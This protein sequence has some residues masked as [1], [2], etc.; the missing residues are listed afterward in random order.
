MSS[1]VR[2]QHVAPATLGRERAVVVAGLVVGA[3]LEVLLVLLWNN[4]VGPG[5]EWSV[6]V[7]ALLLLPS[8]LLNGW[9]LVE[10]VGARLCGPAVPLPRL[11]VDSELGSTHKTV[12]VY[13]LLVVDDNDVDQVIECIRRNRRVAAHRDVGHL[14]AADRRDGSAQSVAD[15]QRLHEELRRRVR[16]LQEEEPGLGPVGAVVREQ[17]QNPVSGT[18]MGWERKRG[19]LLELA[20]AAVSGD[21][22]GYRSDPASSAILAG[23]RYLMVLDNGTL[24]HPYTIRELVG[25]LAHDAAHGDGRTA[26]AQPGYRLVPPDDPNWYQRIVFEGYVTPGPEPQ[27]TLFS[28]MQRM[29]GRDRYGGQALVAVEPFLESLRGRIP[30]NAVLSH[31]KLEGTYA[32]TQHVGDAVILGKPVRSFFEHRRRQ[33]RWI[34]G[35]VQLVPWLV[36]RH[37]PPGGL[38]PWDRLAMTLDIVVFAVDVTAPCLMLLAWALLDGPAAAV[39]TLAVPLFAA[40]RFLPILSGELLRGLPGGVRAFATRLRR[41]LVSEG[42]YLVFLADRATYT[43]KAIATSL[44]RVTVTRRNLLE[45]QP[46]AAAGR[47]VAANP[48]TRW[49]T[50]MWPG[51]LLS[52]LATGWFVAA[53]APGWYVYVVLGI[54]VL[55]PP[56]CAVLSL[57]VHRTDSRDADTN[58]A[59]TSDAGA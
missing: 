57:P 9:R 48:R 32:K 17:R 2:E 4:L 29:L 5:I 15:E 19:N 27:P 34:R 44:W 53:G 10:A 24:L 18:W 49:L 16:L 31:D 40:G 22:S 55:A 46:R 41:L 59:D 21:L 7:V 1:A 43:A 56:I 14:V 11:D 26:I 36:G 47:A 13:P 58:A 35:D 42:L 51:A 23:A 20:A 52:A 50:E 33:A 25:V 37:A 3:A 12:V 38:R 54:W 6:P 8:C 39:A 45:W 30:D 28:F